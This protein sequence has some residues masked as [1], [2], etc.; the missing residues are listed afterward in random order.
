MEACWLTAH[1]LRLGSK[2]EGGGLRKN[3]GGLTKLHTR[4]RA[5]TRRK[6]AKLVGLRCRCVIP[7]GL[8]RNLAKC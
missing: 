7:S 2:W 8:D 5:W 3:R 6:L 1:V 4:R